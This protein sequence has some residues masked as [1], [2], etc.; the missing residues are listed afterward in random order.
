MTDRT[1]TIS[2]ELTEDY[3]DP[4]N[5]ADNVRE[6]TLTF[7]DRVYHCKK[8]GTDWYELYTPEDT[9]EYLHT[10]RFD[11]ALKKA[12]ARIREIE[13][14]RSLATLREKIARDKTEDTSLIRRPVSKKSLHEVEDPDRYL[15]LIHI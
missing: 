6:Y 10:V 2:V 9:T 12:K 5:N 1:P 4:E 14:Q 11:H 8:F 3:Q 13:E 7:G 15:S